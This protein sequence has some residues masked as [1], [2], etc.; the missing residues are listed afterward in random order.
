MNRYKKEGYKIKYHTIVFLQSS[1]DILFNTLIEENDIEGLFEFLI[2]WECGERY[3][4]RDTPGHGTSD[5]VFNFY[6]GPNEYLLSVNYG[7]N[8]A[9]LTSIEFTKE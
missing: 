8:Y 3:D 1:D 4:F 2:Q 7:L 6:D 5:H 9:G